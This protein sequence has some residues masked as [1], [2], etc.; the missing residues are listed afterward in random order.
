MKKQLSEMTNEELWELFP[1]ILREHDPQWTTCYRRE[2]AII[3]NAAGKDN[4]VRINHIGSTAVSGLLAKPTVDILLEITDDC[5]TEKLI[6][7]I[8]S[9]GYIYTE[10]QGNPPPHMMFLKGYTPEGFVGQA[11]HVHV[12]YAGNWPELYFRDYLK[13]HK[14]VADEYGRFKKSL[15]EKYEHDRDGYTSAKTEFIERH[16]T[17]AREEY[18]G[19]YKKLPQ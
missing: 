2:S 3:V 12:R 19:R 17:I 1:I 16:T 18:K 15:L 7:D 13:E 6:K 9:A 8:E 10:Q 5:D 11:F 14:D 4:I